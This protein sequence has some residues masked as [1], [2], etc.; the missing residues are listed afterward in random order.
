VNAGKNNASRDL[1]ALASAILERLNAD[2]HPG[3]SLVVA[4]GDTSI[5]LSTG[6]A[7]LL[8]DAPALPMSE[9]I[10]YDMCSVS[11]PLTA[12]AVLKLLLARPDVSLESKIAPLLP[13][14][15]TIHPS[16]LEITFRHLLTHTSGIGTDSPTYTKAR[17]CMATPL[18]GPLG[19]FNY[20]GANYTLLRVLFAPLVAPGINTVMKD[21][22]M[23]E[24]LTSAIYASQ[25]HHLVFRPTGVPEATLLSPET[26]PGLG[27]GSGTDPGDGI[28]F[29]DGISTAGPSGWHLTCAEAERVFRILHSTELI[30][31]KSLA[32]KM[33]DEHLGY[34]QDTGTIGDVTWF[35]KGGKLSSGGGTIKTRILCFSNGVTM[36]VIVNS[37]T[38]QALPVMTDEFKKWY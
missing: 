23:G 12:A 29:R 13:G 17:K 21:D 19:V 7:R 31:P 25:M 28:Q 35:T 14:Y 3:V 6:W 32:K 8:E 30:L 16:R 11:K 1:A 26:Y 24:V 15:W 27:Y 5:A 4:Y 18:E 2:K 9:H 34:D 20:E 36:M 22:A 10:R 37:D 33:A 38:G